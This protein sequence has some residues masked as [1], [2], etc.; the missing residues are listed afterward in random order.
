MREYFQTGDEFAPKACA[1]GLG[2]KWGIVLGVP[3]D[4]QRKAL[5]REHGAGIVADWIS[6]HPGSR[7]WAWWRWDAQ[8]P[9]RVVAGAEL[10]MPKTAPT[11]FEGVWRDHLG[12]PAFVQ[13][14]PR[15]YAG[16][17]AV[18]G[19]GVYLKRLR[20]VRPGERP[21]PASLQ[22]ASIDPF[23]IAEGDLDGLQ[24]EYERRRAEDT[25][26]RITEQAGATLKNGHR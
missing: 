11:D 9:R 5:W 20:L 18:E 6:V 16:L 3:S 22:P 8:E 2:T 4:E 10:L 23:L 21:S 26:R 19:Q 25:P 17:P 12:V 7:P 14:R 1:A 24:A 15:G 13:F